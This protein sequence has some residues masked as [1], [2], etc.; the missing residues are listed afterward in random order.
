MAFTKETARLA[1]EKRRQKA[2][3]PDVPDEPL[4]TVTPPLS[5]DPLAELGALFTQMAG[6]KTARQEAAEEALALLARLNP[7]EHP[8]IADDP[9][10]QAFVERVQG[11]KAQSADVPPGTVIGTGLTAFK[12]PWSWHDLAEGKVEWVTFTCPER[13]RVGYNGLFWQFLA[14]EETYCPKAFVDVYRETMRNRK[15]SEQHVAY[16]FRQRG[17]APTRDMLDPTGA[18]VAAARVAA[19][20]HDPMGAPAHYVPGGGLIAGSVEDAEA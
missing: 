8:E 20:H 5:D 3:A 1:A 15:F 18:G 7:T 19:T 9:R 13:I 6:K 14:N 12:K 11:A 4:A 17:A 2:A 16:L 10:V